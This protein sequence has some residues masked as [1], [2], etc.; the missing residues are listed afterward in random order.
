MSVR[1]SGLTSS[2]SQVP[3]V[4]EKA[5]VRSESAGAGGPGRCADAAKATPIVSASDVVNR[6]ARRR[7]RRDIMR[8]RG[9]EGESSGRAR[10]PRPALRAAG[11]P[12]A[13]EST[14]R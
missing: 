10:V 12:S 13:L 1:P 6:A 14:R 9:S 5:M 8:V 11:S 2:E 7:E 3:S 4:V